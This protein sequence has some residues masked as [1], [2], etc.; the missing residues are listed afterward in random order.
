MIVKKQK[1]IGKAAQ[2]L[3]D[4]LK[5]VIRKCKIRGVIDYSKEEKCQDDLEYIFDPESRLKRRG[6][7]AMKVR[8]LDNPPKRFSVW[9]SIFLV[10]REVFIS[11]ELHV[12]LFVIKL[13]ISLSLSLFQL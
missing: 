12:L 2:Y 1:K 5:K 9:G 13:I 4:P 8:D 6:S 10:I 11:F 7:K 3:D